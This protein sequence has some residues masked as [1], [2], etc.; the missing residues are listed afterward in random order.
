MTKTQPTRNLTE[1]LFGLRHE[2]P[3]ARLMAGFTGFAVAVA[4]ILVTVL[5]VE[6]H[7]GVCTLVIEAPTS[8]CTMD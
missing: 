5:P 3:L 1:T 8:S 6:A 4:L 7:R 2:N